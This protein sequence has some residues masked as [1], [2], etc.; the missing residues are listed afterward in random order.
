MVVRP[1][2]TYAAILW[3]SRV[4]WKTVNLNS[5]N[6][7]GQ[8]I[9]YTWSYENGFYS[10]ISSSPGTTSSTFDA[11]VKVSAGIYKLNCNKQWKP[12]LFGKDMLTCF[13]TW[14][15]NVSYKW[16]LIKW[17]KKYV[18]NKPF[19]VQFPDRD[20]LESGFQPDLVHRS[21][22]NEGTGDVYAYSTRKKLS[23]N[24]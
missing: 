10:W 2:P 7:K 8:S 15:R 5:T 19:M 6:C 24:H 12:N 16:W 17:K 18:F 21:K 14:R 9:W 13:R 11:E 1:V 4:N 20:E 22:T 23:Y 3:W